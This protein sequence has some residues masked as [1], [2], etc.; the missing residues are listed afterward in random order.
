MDKRP[1]LMTVDRLFSMQ[2]WLMAYGNPLKNLWQSVEKNSG[3]QLI[4]HAP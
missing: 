2:A 1:V 3:S 4:A